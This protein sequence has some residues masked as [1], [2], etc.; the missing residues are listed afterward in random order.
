M[1]TNMP[2]PPSKRRKVIHMFIKE[3]EKS[4]FI[5]F[6]FFKKMRPNNAIA[7]E[8][9]S[10]LDMEMKANS[11]PEKQT[12]SKVESP[13]K[14]ESVEPPGEVVSVSNENPEQVHSESDSERKLA[15]KARK[16]ERKAKR[17]AERKAARKAEKAKAKHV[18]TE[19]SLEVIF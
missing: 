8:K 11:S 19:N 3:E 10:K 15:K 17:K 6:L 7:K 14:G 9:Q 16:Q 5:L 13:V 2:V 12:D 18:K 4:V 1:P